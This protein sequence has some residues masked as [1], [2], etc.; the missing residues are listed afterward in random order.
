MGSEQN[1]LE[2]DYLHN[3]DWKNIFVLQYFHESS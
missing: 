1:E 3:I 2:Q